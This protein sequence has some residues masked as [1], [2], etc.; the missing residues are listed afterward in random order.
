MRNARK[1][2]L[3]KQLDI[4]FATL[5]SSPLSQSWR[6]AAD[7]W[8]LYAAVTSSVMAMATGAS[9]A[10]I[11]SAG[12]DTALEP[13]PNAAATGRRSAGSRN[14]GLINAAR[15][16]VGRKP[17]D[18]TAQATSGAQP[19]ITPGGIVPI[20]GTVNTIQPGE[21]VSI[22]GN[23]LATQ[24]ASWS[25]NFPTTLGGTSVTING[26]A[27]YLLYVSPVQINLQAPDDSATGTV[28]VVVMTPSGSVTS[29][30][31]LSAF[32]P[33]FSVTEIAQLNREFVAGVISRANGR[34]AYGGGSYDI[35]GPP[36]SYAGVTTTPAYPGDVV[37]LYG[38]GFGPT[39]PHVL[40]G[41]LFSGAAPLS[42]NNTFRLYINNFPVTPSFVG[43][44]SAGLYQI[45]F[46]VPPGI[47]QGYVPIR[48]MAG[49]MQTQ[50]NIWFPLALAPGGGTGFTGGSTFFPGSGFS[51]SSGGS[52][53]SSA[54][55]KKNRKRRYTPRLQYPGKSEA[56]AKQE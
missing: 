6:R 14:I 42:P 52:F 41:Q 20:F 1:F 2:D 54:R 24:T 29:S 37:S 4:H 9:A 3:R 53:G 5:Q 43:I 31:T 45:N 48:A 7:S 34:G 10:V 32:A 56:V 12:P 35:L 27:A 50:A 17:L 55:P 23:N 33:S 25:G 40:A 22:Y 13:S 46:T 26:K 38:V 39:T 15:A 51:F 21:W 44:S 19:S 28:S 16:A 47:G 8:R 30:V 11:G 49:G 36:G 18:E